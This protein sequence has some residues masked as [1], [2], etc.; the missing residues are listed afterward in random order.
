MK[1]KSLS[2]FIFLIS[3]VFFSCFNPNSN[4]GSGKIALNLPYGKVV[5][6]EDFVEP[7]VTDV[8]YFY[9][10]LLENESKTVSIEKQAF[11]GNEIL[12]EDLEAG[13]WTITAAATSLE[14]IESLVAL[15]TEKKA[16]ISDIEYTDKDFALYVGK[17]SVFVKGGEVSEAI[18]RLTRI[19]RQ[20]QVV[21]DLIATNKYDGEVPVQLTEDNYLDFIRENIELSLELLT[22]E[23]G[24]L[25]SSELEAISYDELDEA[26]SISYLPT[27]LIFGFIPFDITYAYDSNYYSTRIEI[28]SAVELPEP[29]YDEDFII[30]EYEIETGSTWE[31]TADPFGSNYNNLIYYYAPKAEDCNEIRLYVTP[32]AIEW[33]KDG[34]LVETSRSDKEEFS[35]TIP[36]YHDKAGTYTY[37]CKVYYEAQ[38]WDEEVMTYEKAVQTYV[39]PLSWQWESPEITV[40]V[41]G[42]D[43]VVYDE[44]TITY[45][46]GV[47]GVDAVTQ[48]VEGN[49]P[50]ALMENPFENENYVLLG[51]SLYQNGEKLYD[52]GEEVTLTGDLTL[53]AIWTPVVYTITFDVDG[54]EEIE[55][56]EYTFGQYVNLPTATKEGYSFEGWRLGDEIV[57]TVSSG[58]VTLVAVW[59]VDTYQISLDSNGGQFSEDVNPTLSYSFGELTLEDLPVPS[60][61]GFIFEGWKLNGEGE[62]LTELPSGNI[63]LTACWIEMDTSGVHVTYEVTATSNMEIISQVAGNVVTITAILNKALL[64]EK[65][66]FVWKI[67]GEESDSSNSDTIVLNLTEVGTYYV[68]CYVPNEDG[69]PVADGRV[70]IEVKD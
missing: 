51:W 60:R 30:T 61:I 6:S 64:N 35:Y 18:V 10:I 28:E 55:P 44:Y 50:T 48:I 67:N 9:C 54:G 62:I 13:E 14:N 38:I 7:V 17:S 65:T 59:T 2:V 36:V 24:E 27:G 16:D 68:Y 42:D 32:V 29:E 70:V 49:V 5:Y 63:K 41:T 22:Y 40:E 20:N 33:Y 11:S 23:E 53:Y 45:I 15:F 12:F 58:D 4:S 19:R 46:S 31:I 56:M 47:E 8:P 69:L 21:G 34:V 66:T 52:L 25:I 39:T 37:Q 26:L 43:I 1:N 3:F 57:Q